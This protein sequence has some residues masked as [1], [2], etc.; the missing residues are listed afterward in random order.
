M[1]LDGS[2]SGSFD[3]DAAAET[4]DESLSLTTDN[5]TWINWGRLLSVAAGFLSTVWYTRIAEFID[6]VIQAFAIAPLNA[7]GDVLG[8]ATTA[9]LGT[10]PAS[11][12]GSFRPAQEFIRDLGPEAF[13]VALVLVVATSYALSRGLNRDG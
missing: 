5:G 2:P 11:I 1:A 4:V 13:I 12:R 7:L 9:F 10:I 8:G 6:S 3:D